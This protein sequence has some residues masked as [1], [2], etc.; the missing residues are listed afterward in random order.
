MKP[1]TP[2]QK[3][4][5]SYSRDGRNGYGQNSKA[6]LKSITKRKRDPN[7]ANRRQAAALLAG[8]R[9]STP[10]EALEAVETKL[11]GKR[12]KT[13]QKVADL[14]LAS[15]VEGRLRRRAK[16]GIDDPSTVEAR[17]RR[18]RRRASKSRRT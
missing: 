12:P 4:R 15:W 18:V 16:L 10:G 14:P 3:K 6:S 2:Q 11:A 7:R 17:V 13:W 8:A 9:G 1:K 5:A